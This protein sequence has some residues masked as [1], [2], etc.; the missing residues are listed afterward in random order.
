M[1]KSELRRNLCWNYLWENMYGT[2]NNGSP[3][4]N[5]MNVYSA[6]KIALGHCFRS[7]EGG[8]EGDLKSFGRP[9]FTAS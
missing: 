8:Q 7:V 1:Q 3:H 9:P 4:V 6:M 5:L 2:P